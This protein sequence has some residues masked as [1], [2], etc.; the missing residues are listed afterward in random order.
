MCKIL[1]FYWVVFIIFADL[2]LKL[3][4]QISCVLK[5]IL[6]IFFKILVSVIASCSIFILDLNT[7]NSLSKCI[8][9]HWFSDGSTKLT[10]EWVYWGKEIPSQ[11]IRTQ[12]VLDLHKNAAKKTLTTEKNN[13]P[14][15]AGWLKWGWWA[16]HMVDCAF[17]KCK[18]R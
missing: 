17:M 7:D 10:D 18:I 6:I 3:F 16:I 13:Y 14:D 11:L 15:P 1:N 9:L 8:H 12:I 4:K 2:K 5:F